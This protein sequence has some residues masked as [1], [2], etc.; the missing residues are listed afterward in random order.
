MLV[1]ERFCTLIACSGVT[2]PEYTAAIDQCATL[3]MCHV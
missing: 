1:A 3:V 2:L